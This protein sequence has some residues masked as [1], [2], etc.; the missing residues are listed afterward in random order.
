M[1]NGRSPARR[2]AR[3]AETRRE[4]GLCRSFVVDDDDLNVVVVVVG[5][6][7]RGAARHDASSPGSV[8][9][10]HVDS[11]KY[12]PTKLLEFGIRPERWREKEPAEQARE[13]WKPSDCTSRTNQHHDDVAPAE[14]RA[15]I[16]R[17]LCH[18]PFPRSLQP[19]SSVR[20]KPDGVGGWG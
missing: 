5:S 10:N 6:S 14:S 17:S 20:P 13:G 9:P 16:G 2:F 12:L 4:S 3:F 7:R 8:K 11:T 1:K 18:S 15:M 19:S